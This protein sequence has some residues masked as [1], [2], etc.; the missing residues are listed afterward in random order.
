[1]SS[2]GHL[3]VVPTPPSPLADAE[4][5][6]RIQKI[7]T[8]LKRAQRQGT[9]GLQRCMELQEQLRAEIAARSPEQVARMERARGLC[10]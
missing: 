5:E 10:R 7:I 6:A 8:D 4:R 1:M 2:R 9:F 3:S